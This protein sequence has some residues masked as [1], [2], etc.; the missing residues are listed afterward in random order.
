VAANRH[1]IAD[2]RA[3]GAVSDSVR[4]DFVHACSPGQSLAPRPVANFRIAE[5]LVDDCD[6]RPI[7][8]SDVRRLLWGRQRNLDVASMGYTRSGAK[9]IVANGI[10]NFLGICINSVAVFLFSP[11][12]LVSGRDRF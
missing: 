7:L 12:I 3:T 10:K 5:E 6:C 4:D 11:R 1:A 9:Y 8:L 2:F